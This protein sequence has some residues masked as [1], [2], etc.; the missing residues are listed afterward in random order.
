MTKNL[1]TIKE[2]ISRSIGEWKSLRS[3]H[4]LAFQEFEN[5]HSKI[6]IAFVDL[7]NSEVCNLLNESKFKSNA[8]FAII[9]KW[10]SESDWSNELEIN[11][12]KNLFV[13]S[14]ET[15]KSGIILRNKGYA[16]QISSYSTYSIDHN[17]C[18]NLQTTY[19]CTTS[20]EKVWFLSNNVRSRYSIIRNKSSEGII[21]TS[22]STEIRKIAN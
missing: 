1:I 16:E 9:I 22:H 2:F 3:T 17:E 4:S 21:Q 11:H 13:F 20:E 8:E 5:T 12:D 19:N 15:T 6:K 18:L 10:I 14:P 7:N